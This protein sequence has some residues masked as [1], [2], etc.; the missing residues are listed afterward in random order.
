MQS[1]HALVWMS[2]VWR[3]AAPPQLPE[4]KLEVRY[5]MWLRGNW[6]SPSSK[7]HFIRTKSF[8][9]LP[10]RGRGQINLKVPFYFFVLGF[11]DCFF[12][13]FHFASGEMCT[14]KLS[15]CHPVSTARKSHTCL[16]VFIQ[17]RVHSKN[18]FWIKQSKHLLFGGKLAAGLAH[19]TLA[20]TQHPLFLALC[21]HKM[22]WESAE[23]HKTCSDQ[24]RTHL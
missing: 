10:N 1:W 24:C 21:I 16:G 20:T 12:F 8:T 13:S 18:R 11:Y 3:L 19:F 17:H 7:S 9:A 6:V 4:Q 2:Y 23:K 14:L 22:M 5:W 15:D